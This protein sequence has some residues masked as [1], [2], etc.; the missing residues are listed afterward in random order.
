MNAA[1]HRRRRMRTAEIGT[2]TGA[3]YCALDAR[4]IILI[5]SQAKICWFVLELDV[6]T[7]SQING[8][9]IMPGVKKWLRSL[10]MIIAGIGP[11]VAIIFAIFGRWDI[12]IF[13]LVAATNC[14]IGYWMSKKEVRDE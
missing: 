14:E 4:N 5:S 6:F 10:D 8:G 7:R 1:V 12:A 13:C 2:K 11:D 3:G 9:R